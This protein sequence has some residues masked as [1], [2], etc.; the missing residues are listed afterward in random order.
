MSA[1]ETNVDLH[2]L[3]WSFLYISTIKTQVV[4]LKNKRGT[5]KYKGD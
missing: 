4:T 3:R 1:T 2:N 5:L